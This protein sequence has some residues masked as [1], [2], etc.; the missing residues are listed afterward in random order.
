VIIPAYNPSKQLI[1]TIESLKQSMPNSMI[2]LVNDGSPKCCDKFLSELK[3][4]FNLTLLN[5]S[6]NL[7]KGAA[8]KT[9]F[10]YCIV[11]KISTPGIITTDADGQH[12]NKDIAN[13]HD[14]FLTD[15][16]AL[17]IGSRTFSKSSTPWRSRFGNKLTAF[18][19]KKLFHTPI[20]DTQSGLR[21]IPWSLIPRL[22]MLKTNGFEFELEMLIVAIKNRVSIKAI[23]MQTVYIDKNKGSSFNPIID[24]VKIYRIFL[25]YLMARFVKYFH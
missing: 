3:Y 9:G 5:H 7:G 10:N 13:L 12:L 24:S 18:I 4:K 14:K 16:H 21:A 8:L 11:N 15:P 23:P 22:V 20:Q 17:W 1:D 2:I 19:F 25:Q 6:R